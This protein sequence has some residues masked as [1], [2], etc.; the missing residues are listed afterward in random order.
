MLYQ[1]IRQYAQAHGGWLLNKYH[2]NLGKAQS[3]LRSSIWVFVIGTQT[4]FAAIEVFLVGETFSH[5]FDWLLI[6]ATVSYYL[7]VKHHMSQHF[8]YLQGNSYLP[9]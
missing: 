6:L 5:L 4:I 3:S 7:L 9:M 8:R 2:M 1:L